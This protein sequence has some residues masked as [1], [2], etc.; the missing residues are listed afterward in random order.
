MLVVPLPCQKLF[1]NCATE[2]VER[3]LPLVEIW[4]YEFVNKLVECNAFI[5]SVW[6][7]CT[8]L[9]GEFLFEIFAA[10]CVPMV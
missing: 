8:Q 6:R 5:N 1:G 9:N 4:P 2:S 7:E 10:S 3:A